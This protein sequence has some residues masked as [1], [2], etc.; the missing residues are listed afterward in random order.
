MKSAIV[1][2]LRSLDVEAAKGYFNTWF[3][4][5]PEAQLNGRPVS[6]EEV[7][8]AGLHKGRIMHP[9]ISAKMKSQSAEWLKANGYQ[10]PTVLHVNTVRRVQ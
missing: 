5:A 10:V 9:K 6:R 1:R 8:L 4:D 3:P 2:I 7:I